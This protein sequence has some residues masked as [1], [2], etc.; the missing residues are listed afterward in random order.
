MQTVQPRAGTG[1]SDRESR[2]TLADAVRAVRAHVLA[3]STWRDVAPEHRTSLANM[4]AYLALRSLDLRAL[5]LRLS[6]AGLSS[7]GR[8][9]TH[10][11]ATLEAV[12]GAA[13]GRPPAADEPR[14]MVVGFDEAPSLLV[15]NAESVFGAAPAGRR[16]RVMIT[17]PSAAATDEI[18][19]DEL[20]RRGMDVARINTAHDDASVW[21][22]MIRNVR[23][24]AAAAGR[25]VRVLVDL[26]GPKVRTGPLAPRPAALHVKPVRDAFGRVVGP[27]RALLAHGPVR[28]DLPHDV[29]AIPVASDVRS[30]VV[31][32]RRLRLV[33]ARGANRL[34]RIAAIGE[35]G[36]LV[37]TVKSTYVVPGTTLRSV[38]DRAVAV[39]VAG[40]PG[41]EGYLEVRT[42]DRL[43][44]RRDLT[45]AVA[46]SSAIGCR[47]A[48]VVESLEIGHRVYFDDGKVE[49]VVDELAPGRAFVRVTAT[50]GERVKLRA[51]K[52]IN[53]PDTDLPLDAL[54]DADRRA[55]VEVA[56]HCDLVGLS[57][58]RRASDVERLHA[59]L[60]RLGA[61]DRGIVV[62]VETSEGFGNLPD[63]LRVLLRRRAAAVM[64]ARGD[65]AVEVG[66]ARLAE[67]QEEIMWLCASAHVPVIWATQVLEHLARTGIPAR[68]EITDAAMAERAECV[69][70]NKGPYIAEALTALDDILVRMETH[71]DKKFPLLR[72]LAAWS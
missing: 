24:A 45:P 13:E 53:V 58:V 38:D 32:G 57:F 7:L 15:R 3:S 68:G 23:R 65:L 25:E 51:D 54:T 64:I 11:V 4:E 43:E 40:F 2:R 5:Q 1:V 46:G 8:C 9:E 44:L 12:I 55:L 56:A 17:L 60:D 59:E 69:M 70:L 10:V 71:Q 37:E 30:R 29:V 6:R 66:Y 63:V 61:G 27:G 72:R 47:P 20:V 33:D 41:N 26:A 48:E 42:G 52:G 35:Q 22:G 49:S 21:L 50:A 62:K 34:V 18:L 16:T 67:V 19:V 39:A 28:G 14:G 31:T 36:V